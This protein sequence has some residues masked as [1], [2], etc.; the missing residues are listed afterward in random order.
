MSRKV[1]LDERIPVTMKDEVPNHFEAARMMFNDWMTLLDE[2]L[3]PASHQVRNIPIKYQ[4]LTTWFQECPIMNFLG[5]FLKSF[6]CLL[7]H[8]I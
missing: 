5:S 3:N 2:L 8:I 1:I 4:L 6:V 7:A